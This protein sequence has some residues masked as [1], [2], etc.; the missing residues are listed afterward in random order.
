MKRRL[1]VQSTCIGSKGISEVEA[2]SYIKNAG[3]DCF[4]TGSY[5]LD[6]VSALKNEA[7]KQG[8]DFEFIHAKWHYTDA[9]GGRFFMNE[10]WKPGLSYL[11]LFDATIEAMDSAAAC[12]I[13]G[14]CQH[15]TSGWVAPPACDIGFERFD[16]L[17]DHAVKKGVKLT[18]ENLRNYGLLAV[19]LERY[20]RVPEVGFCYD[21]G[22][23]YCYTE[24]VPFLDLWGKRTYYTHL[25]DNYGRDKEDPAKDAD[26]HLLPYDGTFD[27]GA[28]IEKMDKYGYEGALTLEVGQRKEYQH[29]SPEDFLAMRYERTVRLSKGEK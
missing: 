19:L 14:I 3:F 21:N 25:H 23:E 10:F 12:G 28:M 11:P 26:Y 6:A 29:M 8:L 18:F 7:D 24:T 4:F 22:H 27:Y 13:S 17:V 20:D 16:R 5:K 1:G 2:L 9:M 15:I